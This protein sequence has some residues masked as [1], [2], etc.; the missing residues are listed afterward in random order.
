MGLADVW[1]AEIPV[2]EVKDGDQIQ[3][4]IKDLVNARCDLLL[5]SPGLAINN[6]ALF[7][8]LLQNIEIVFVWEETI[9]FDDIWIG[10]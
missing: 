5:A 6:A 7:H 10:Q 1:L 4:S 8:K 9:Y 3:D 2:L